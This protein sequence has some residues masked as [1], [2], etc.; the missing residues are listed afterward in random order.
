MPVA[1]YSACELEWHRWK[2]VVSVCGVVPV[3]AVVPIV[4]AGAYRHYR[5]ITTAAATSPKQTVP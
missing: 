1:R 3:F 2:L 4:P 5:G